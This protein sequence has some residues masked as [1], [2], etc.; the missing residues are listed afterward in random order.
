MEK[1][2]FDQLT[3]NI[4][5]DGFLSSVPLCQENA[6][7]ELEVLSGNHRVKAAIEADI[8]RI[9]IMTIPEQTNYTRQTGGQWRPEQT[10]SKKIAIQLSH[11]AISGQDDVDLL[12]N[13]WDELESLDEQL[14]SGLESSLFED[15]EGYQFEGF[16]AATPKTR[17]IG[18]WFLPEEIEQ[19]DD[20][21]LELEQNPAQQQTYLASVDC[22]DR[23]IDYIAQTKKTM[24]IKNT[25]TAFLRLIHRLDSEDR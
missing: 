18:I 8:D 4:Q 25:A 5:Q 17:F 24:K 2:Q 1:N 7:G 9:L 12:K 6:D 19:F 20:L 10:N 22:Y 15:F 14:Y 21:L 13:L 11:N 23:L 16:T 3:Q